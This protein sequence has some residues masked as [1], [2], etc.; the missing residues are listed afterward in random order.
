MT[1]LLTALTALAMCVLAPIGLRLLSTRLPPARVWAAAGAAATIG[2]LL[3]R[4]AG[5]VLLCL[6]YAGVCATAAGAGV[7]RLLAFAQTRGSGPGLDVMI[8]EAAAVTAAVS[9]AVAGGSLLAERGGLALLGFDLVTLRLTVLHFHY[10]GFAAALVAG[11][12]AATWPSALSRAGAVA[13]PAGLLVVLCGFF[14][15]DWAELLGAVLLTAGLL[16]TSTALL[17]NQLRLPLRAR[18]LLLIT[19]AAL[20][21]T[22]LLAVSWA[23]GEAADLPHLSLGQTAAT[24]GLTNALCAGMCGVLG[25]RAADVPPL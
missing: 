10:A 24:H 15:G 18:R 20:P 25:W 14:I 5:A 13:V 17:R 19:A 3:P 1:A 12:A 4:G 11:H 21:V 16:A 23:L 6:P 7:L 22:M 2:L 9:L 8:R